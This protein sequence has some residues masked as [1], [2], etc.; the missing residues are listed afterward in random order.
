MS[1]ITVT[2]A[3]GRDYTGHDAA[4]EAWSAGKDFILHDIT[5]PWCGRPC[6]IR[7]FPAGTI[8]RI[9]YN[10]LRHVTSVTIGEPRL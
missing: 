1:H 4:L 6:S 5:S 8:V 7:D 2:P 9:R 10:R 3:Y